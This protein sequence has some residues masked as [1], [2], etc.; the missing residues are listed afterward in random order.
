MST[1]LLYF[2]AI[3]SFVRFYQVGCI[4][5][6]KEYED[7]NCSRICTDPKL[8]EVVKNTCYRL[9]QTMTI[10][11]P[12]T[13]EEIKNKSGCEKQKSVRLIDE[14]F[15][16]RPIVALWK[17]VGMCYLGKGTTLCITMGERET[18]IEQKDPEKDPGKDQRDVAIENNDQKDDKKDGKDSRKLL[19]YS[20]SGNGCELIE[21]NAN[22]EMQV[23]EVPPEPPKKGYFDVIVNFLTSIP[24]ILI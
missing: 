6:T 15:E 16:H 3:Y 2:V 4:L 24:S 20:Y 5:T 7:W 10:T 23:F 12:Y 11:E 1:Y 19:V 14:K 9:S 13:E 18:N 17:E 22:Y 8:R 21:N